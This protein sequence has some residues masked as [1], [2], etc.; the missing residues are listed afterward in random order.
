MWSPQ[1]NLSRFCDTD[2]VF[3]L[4]PTRMMMRR[5]DNLQ[6]FLLFSENLLQ[7]KKQFHRSM[8]VGRRFPIC[9]VHIKGSVIEVGAFSNFICVDIRFFHM[10][11]WYIIYHIFCS[12]GFNI[13]SQF[14]CFIFYNSFATGI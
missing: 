1:L 7:I 6:S 12:P 14:S 5:C 9:R 11:L 4:I 3:I 2:L 8:I 10:T 13:L